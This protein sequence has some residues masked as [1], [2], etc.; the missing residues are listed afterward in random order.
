MCYIPIF[1]CIFCGTSWTL[2]KR[3][4]PAV[5]ICEKARAG[6]ESHD[7][8]L[9]LPTCTNRE[10]KSWDKLNLDSTIF[11]SIVE[12]PYPCGACSVTGPRFSQ[13]LELMNK[14]AELRLADLRVRETNGDEYIPGLKVDIDKLSQWEQDEM[15]RKI[16]KL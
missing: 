1:S 13:H 6:I 9:G 14:N 10:Q 5:F 3:Q 7:S 8:Q 11:P 16:M 12:T 4:L 2:A 15:L